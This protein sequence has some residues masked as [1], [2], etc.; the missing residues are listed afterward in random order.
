MRKAEVATTVAQVEEF[1]AVVGTVEVWH[2]GD[3]WGVLRAPDGLSVFCHFSHVDA[4]GYRELHP[5]EPVVFDYSTPGQD[6][7]DATVLPAARVALASGENPPLRRP[8]AEEIDDS[9]AAYRS[10]LTISWD[11]DPST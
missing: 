5:G 6:G 9:T 7:C 8:S 4:P 11:D 1:P 2:A 10:G 3:G